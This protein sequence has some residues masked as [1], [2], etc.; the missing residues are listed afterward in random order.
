MTLKSPTIMT[1]INAFWLFAL[2]YVLTYMFNALVASSV[3]PAVYGD[4]SLAIYFLKLTVPFYILGTNTT[5]LKYLPQYL[6]QHDKTTLRYHL[7]W[8][9]NTVILA[10]LMAFI[11]LSIAGLTLFLLDYAHIRALNNYHLAFF[12]QFIAPLVGLSL[13]I[14]NILL[15]MKRVLLA[16]VLQTIVKWGFYILLFAL[17][18]FMFGRENISYRAL[19][20]VI[21][22]GSLAWMTTSML[23]LLHSINY[24][25]KRYLADKLPTNLALAKEWSRY[26]KLLLLDNSLF[27]FTA[28]IDLLII[29]IIPYRGEHNVGYYAACLTICGLLWVPEKAIAQVLKPFLSAKTTN[30]S[31]QKLLNKGFLLKSGLLIFFTITMVVFA[32]TFL[33]HF[34]PAYVNHADILRLLL[35]G[36]ML[37]LLPSLCVFDALYGGYE[38][39]LLYECYF[40]LVATALFG[41]L[42]YYFFGLIGIAWAVVLIRCLSSYGLFIYVKTRA[43]LNYMLFI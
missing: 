10:M 25:I 35:I 15:A 20:W 27:V 37:S 7:R 32:K 6:S 16:N 31:H 9:L 1:F 39:I 3:P 12:F 14:G 42:A 33:G 22:L 13:L 18:I 2:G 43:K 36:N 5:I 21:F 23:S 19:F 11:V 29:E 4:F 30:A 41:A 17:F 34:G 38:H 28:F 26:S 8:N 40:L 24:D